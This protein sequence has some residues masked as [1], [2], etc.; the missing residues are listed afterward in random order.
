M[1][2]KVAK[3]TLK[4]LREGNLLSQRDVAEM[5]GVSGATVSRYETGEQVPDAPMR[6]RLQELYETSEIRWIDKNA[7]SLAW[8]RYTD[9]SAPKRSLRWWR[10]ERHLS[11]EELSDLAGVSPR[12][13]NSWERGA[14]LTMRPKNR[15]ALAKALM[16]APDKIV[17]PSDAIEEDPAFFDRTAQ[18]RAELRGAQR[19]LRKAY[20]FMVD[21]SNITFKAQDIR[22]DLLP[23]IQREL[24]GT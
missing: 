15:R 20:D 19:A 24:K 22:D 6:G 2:A 11:V 10:Q 8:V 18:I 12:T 21:D 14:T 9:P 23:E 1:E 17:L 5:L 7:A 16:V 3:R 13:I 4:E